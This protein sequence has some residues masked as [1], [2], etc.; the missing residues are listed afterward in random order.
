MRLTDRQMRTLRTAAIAS[1]LDVTDEPDTE[2][3]LGRNVK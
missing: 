1:G 2:F 3:F